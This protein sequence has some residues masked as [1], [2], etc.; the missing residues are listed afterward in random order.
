[1]HDFEEQQLKKIAK[2]LQLNTIGEISISETSSY[3]ELDYNPQLII[4]VNRP[5][6][7]EIITLTL[8]SQ[9]IK[10]EYTPTKPAGA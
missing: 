5:Y 3:S 9:N 7:K 1:M 6:G 4:T 10:T 2:L 8:L